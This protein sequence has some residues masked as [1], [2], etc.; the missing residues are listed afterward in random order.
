MKTIKMKFTLAALLL[1]FSAFS[2]SKVFD[3][4]VDVEVRSTVE[5]TNN[6][7]IVGY[8]FFYQIDK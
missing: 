2:Q 6:K 4:V 8:A 1:C 3:N 5:I 7:Q